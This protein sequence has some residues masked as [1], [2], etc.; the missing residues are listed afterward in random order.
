M[1]AMHNAPHQE[2]RL[3][4]TAGRAH[5]GLPSHLPDRPAITRALRARPS[6]RSHSIT[7]RDAIA[8]DQPAFFRR[9]WRTK[10]SMVFSP[11]SRALRDRSGRARGII[12]S[13]TP[14]TVR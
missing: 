13:L 8:P 12:E 5:T 7:I 4:D 1:Q 11:R 3:E 9:H 6:V 2:R 14:S 10:E